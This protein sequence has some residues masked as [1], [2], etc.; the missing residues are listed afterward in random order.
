VVEL[1]DGTRL[2]RQLIAQSDGRATLIRHSMTPV[3]PETDR[4]V[5]AASPI[6]FVQRQM[7][8]HLSNR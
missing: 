8:A 4:V 2:L 1:Q 5:V 3:P 6:E 7:P